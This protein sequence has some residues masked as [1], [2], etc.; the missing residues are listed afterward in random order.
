MYRVDSHWSLGL[1]SGY[2]CG[3]GYGSGAGTSLTC[4]VRV[5]NVAV[6]S[7]GSGGWILGCFSRTESGHQTSG[8]SGTSAG[9]AR[10]K[11]PPFGLPEEYGYRSN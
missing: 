2:G 8:D 1:L 6:V 3:C 7:D 11:V 4:R 10:R 5:E 9:L